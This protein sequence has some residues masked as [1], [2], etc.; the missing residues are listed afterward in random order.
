MCVSI[1]WSRDV[2]FANIIFWQKLKDGLL[3]TNTTLLRCAEETKAATSPMQCN[4]DRY[5]LVCWHRPHDI[6]VIF[7]FRGSVPLSLT[8][9]SE[10]YTSISQASS[11]P[12]SGKNKSKSLC[13][14]PRSTDSVDTHLKHFKT[15]THLAHNLPLFFKHQ[16]TPQS[17]CNS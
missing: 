10:L 13:A 15:P 7:T 9:E 16:T 12:P 14:L 11:A 4:D 5:L 6:L 1:C 2:S 8:P 3:K 17:L